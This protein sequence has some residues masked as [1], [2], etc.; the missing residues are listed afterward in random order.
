MEKETEDYIMQLEKRLVLLEGRVAMLEVN[1]AYKH[2]PSMP[3]YAKHIGCPVCGIGG[4]GKVMGY[5]CNRS[6]C[7][8]RVTC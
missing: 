2:V 5:V 6:D 4:D 7:P 1:Q 3:K 8:T